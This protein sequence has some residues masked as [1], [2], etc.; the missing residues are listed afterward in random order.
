MFGGTTVVRREPIGVIG[1]IV[2]GNFPQG[3]PQAC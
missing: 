1:G 2:P 3:C